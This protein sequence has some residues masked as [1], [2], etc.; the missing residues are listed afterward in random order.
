M[1]DNDC[2][3]VGMFCLEPLP[4]VVARGLRRLTFLTEAFQLPLSPCRDHGLKPRR[5]PL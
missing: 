2:T 5:T 3:I 4:P 1:S